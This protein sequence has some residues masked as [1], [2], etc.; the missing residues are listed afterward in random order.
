MSPLRENKPSF[1]QLV[2]IS[3][4]SVGDYREVRQLEI[5]VEPVWA[6]DLEAAASRARLRVG[7]RGSAPPLPVEAPVPPKPKRLQCAPGPRPG[8]PQPHFPDFNRGA[9][10]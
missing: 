2:S 10:A 5:D 6:F 8:I 9:W 3:S 1:L 7:S 4:H